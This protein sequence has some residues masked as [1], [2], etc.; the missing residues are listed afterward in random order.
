MVLTGFCHK[1]G[2]QG[3]FLLVL[4]REA[5]NSNRDRLRVSQH[6]NQLTKHRASNMY[7]LFQ[8]DSLY[9]S[10]YS[11]RGAGKPDWFSLTMSCFIVLGQE[12]C[13]RQMQCLLM[14]T[15]TSHN[16][17]SISQPNP[18]NARIPTSSQPANSHWDSP[19][20]FRIMGLHLQE[21]QEHPFS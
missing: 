14:F 9:F 21:S 8:S 13:P 11:L 16:A 7:F 6:P 10:N 18:T 4:E 5:S 3:F 2:L 12:T 20:D 15:F 1:K 19:T 17:C